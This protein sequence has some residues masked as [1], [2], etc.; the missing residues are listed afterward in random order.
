TIEHELDERDVDAVARRLLGPEGLTEKR[1][2]FTRP[3]AVM[4]WAHAHTAGAPA[5][6]VLSLAER[7]VADDRVAPLAPETPGRPAAFSTAEL[8]RYERV[9]LELAEHGRNADAPTVSPAAIARVL[10]ERGRELAAEQAALLRAV[11]SIPD[12]IVCVVGHAGAGK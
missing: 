1:S 9:A 6:R 10:R 8:L 2:T 5:E 4:A 3:E 12:R 7:L 11:A